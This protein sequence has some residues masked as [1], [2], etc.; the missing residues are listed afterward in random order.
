MAGMNVSMWIK[1][2]QIIPKIS[3]EE[4]DKLDI[5]SRW[6]IATRAAVLVT[7][8]LSAAFAGI[9]AFR[10]GSFD[11]WRW[12]LVTVGLFLAHGTNNFLN[13]YT[14][15]N[16]GVDVD[17]YYRAQYGPQPLL[18]GLMTKK[19]L[20]TYAAVTGAM[21][22]A[23]G[24]ALVLMRG[25]ITWLLMA[26]GAF[27]LFFYTYPLKYIAL[28][29]LTI[30]VVWGPLMVAGGYYAISGLP[31][32]WTVALASLPHGMGVTAMLFGKHIDKLQQDKDL[33][34]HTL[35]VVL[36]ETLARWSMTGLLM[37]GYLV[38]IYLIWIRFFTPVMLLTLLAIPTLV[39]IWPILSHPKPDEKP[40]GFPDVWP[41]YYVAAAF[42]HTRRFGGLFLLAVILDT[43]V[44]SIWPAF[45]S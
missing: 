17:N 10:A 33:K 5:I 7:T 45:W 2:L 39:E 35:P 32:D 44:K 29:E 9:F 36:G 23:C 25:G 40:E 8:L 30:F 24:I 22:A 37:L 19:E 28:G 14:D 11:F 27:F 1:A 4:W 3:K 6:L 26:I 15:F 13:D 43:V 21:A 16:R 42:H 41:N 31:W 34:I 38:V 12:L 20:L 18:H